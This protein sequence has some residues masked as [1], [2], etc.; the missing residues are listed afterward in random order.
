MHLVI[1]EFPVPGGM[2][3]TI[4]VP[5]LAPAK[6]FFVLLDLL[7]MVHCCVNACCYVLTAVS[8]AVIADVS[9][10]LNLIF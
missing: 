3:G 6:N 1:V 5:V 2:V 10:L 4:F 8:A 7:L 9:F